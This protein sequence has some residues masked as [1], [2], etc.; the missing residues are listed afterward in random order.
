MKSFRTILKAL[1][2]TL[3][4]AGVGVLVVATIALAVTLGSRLGAEG[5]AGSPDPQA[6]PA[7]GLVTHENQILGYRISLPGVY[8]RSQSAIFSGHPQMLGRD[9]Y[10]FM[11][12]A[13]ERADCQRDA[14][15]V[16][17]QSAGA[18]FDVTAYVAGPT[19]SAVAWARGSAF[20]SPR[21][22]VERATVD[23][24]DAARI[25]EDGRSSSYV[26]NANDRM[27]V[28]APTLWPSQHRLDDIIRSFRAIPM[29]PLPSPTPRLTTPLAAAADHAKA[30]AAAFSAR[31]ADALE[32][33]MPPCRFGVSAVIEPVQRGSEA[34]CILNRSVQAF[35]A[36]L[37]G[38]FARG[39]LAVAVDPQVNV[40]DEGRW[41]DRTE[42]FYVRS[43]WTGGGRTT[44]IDLFLREI[45]GR[46]YWTNARHHYQRGALAGRGTC[47]EYRSPWV[48]ASGSC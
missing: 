41:A 28:M 24:Q 33:L 47:V 13:E 21:S 12:M 29:Q 48:T 31:D 18:Y 39:D 3:H 45:E 16:P 9:S 27:Y 10:T 11:T 37:R 1:A 17:L 42:W 40:L 25:V 36:A 6:S 15:D 8:R 7:S 22:T 23:G 32:R 5:R 35:T 14:G 30:L 38:H 46:W 26:V 19:T 34:C 44:A 20:T 4:I 43:T 2:R